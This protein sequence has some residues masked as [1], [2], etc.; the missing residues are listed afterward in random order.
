M[1]YP[2]KGASYRHEP[3]FIGRM[4]LAEGGIA[5][6]A[7][8]LPRSEDENYKPEKPEMSFPQPYKH[9]DREGAFMQTIV[10]AE[11]N[12]HAVISPDNVYD[13]K[14]EDFPQKSRRGGMVRAQ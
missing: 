8:S 5:R 7:E 3:K 9:R 12:D 6:A 14:S 10:P 11:S 2:E 1:T 4:K 13:W